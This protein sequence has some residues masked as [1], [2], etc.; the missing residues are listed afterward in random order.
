M[1]E[2]ERKRPGCPPAPR[3]GK[4]EDGCKS[5]MMG[6]FAPRLLSFTLK[7]QPVAAIQPVWRLEARDVNLGGH[8]DQSQNEGGGQRSAGKARRWKRGDK[9]D[10]QAQAQ[11]FKGVL[12]GKAVGQRK[13]IQRNREGRQRR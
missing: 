7:G 12:Q 6:R 13:P 1:G 3:A 8:G 9:A 4:I 2:I 10:E 5:A 11:D